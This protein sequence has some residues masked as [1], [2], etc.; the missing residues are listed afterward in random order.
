MTLRTSQAKFKN[1]VAAGRVA[2]SRGFRRDQCLG[3]ENV[4]QRRFQNLAFNDR[5]RYA[6]HGLDGKSNRA[7]G[8]G[9]DVAGELEPLE[10]GEEIRGE[11]R[12]AVVALQGFEILDVAPIKPE[13]SHVFNRIGEAA[14]NRIAAIERIGS[15]EEMKD[16]LG[17]AKPSFPLAIG[18]G[19]LVDIG[20]QREGFRVHCLR[21][22]WISK[23]SWFRLRT[24]V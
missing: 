23:V 7:I 9:I 22:R 4:K 20:E 10:I 18:H 3:I 24:L 15:I 6:H 19:Q 12:L 5:A 17:A 13:L 21:L 11:E 14:N 16:C 2:Y 1:R 8:H